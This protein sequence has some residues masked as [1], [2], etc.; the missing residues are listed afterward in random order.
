[1]L[2][3]H[4]CAWLIRLKS[5]V[6]RK[7]VVAK[8]KSMAVLNAKLSEISKAG[9]SKEV[10]PAYLY[11]ELDDQ[12]FE[13]DDPNK[14]SPLP[15]IPRKWQTASSGPSAEVNLLLIVQ[16]GLLNS[17]L[18]VFGQGSAIKHEVHVVAWIVLLLVVVGDIAFYRFLRGTINRLKSQGALEYVPTDHVYD[19]NRHIY[20]RGTKQLYKHDE[21]GNVRRDHL[22]RKLHAKMDAHA[23]PEIACEFDVHADQHNNA[24]YYEHDAEGNPVKVGDALVPAVPD[25]DGVFA[26]SA[27]PVPINITQPETQNA[28]EI[29]YGDENFCGRL[30]LLSRYNGKTAGVWQGNTDEAAS[31][32]E[33]YGSAFAKFGAFGY[34]YYFVELSR[35]M[36]DCFVLGFVGGATQTGVVTVIHALFNF[37]FVFMMPCMFGTAFVR[38]K[39]SAHSSRLPRSL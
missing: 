10:D 6:R 35:K 4:V 34:L 30:F 14:D 7:A 20:Q 3:R 13:L 1:M 11:P 39:Y 15:F 38:E 25:D 8:Q 22:G 18:T 17:C 9:K 23:F 24:I 21:E 12:Y 36:L 16:M 32:I 26:S 37:A 28:A 5:E 31:F 2:V 33:G 27:K 19:T 29:A